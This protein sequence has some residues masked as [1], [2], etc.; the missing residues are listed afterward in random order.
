MTT[1]TLTFWI[2]LKSRMCWE[3]LQFKQLIPTI[4]R[5]FCHSLKLPMTWT[6]TWPYLLL[7]NINCLFGKNSNCWWAFLGNHQALRQVPVYSSTQCS[8]F[9]S[10][11]KILTWSLISL[12][13]IIM[14][15]N[16]KLWLFQLRT[17]PYL[18]CS[19]DQL[20]ICLATNGFVLLV[21]RSFVKASRPN[22]FSCHGTCWN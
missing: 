16:T 12:K 18:V 11:P 7:N 22:N 8:P 5:L 19:Q 1:L 21:L 15:P 6:F 13:T 4:A 20:S 10:T 9:I 2:S 17:Q 3:A 14:F